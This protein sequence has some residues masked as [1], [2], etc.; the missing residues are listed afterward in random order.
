MY[1]GP[2]MRYLGGKSKVGKR[3]AEVILAHTTNR[4]DYYEPFFGGGGMFKHLGPRFK[5][6]FASD[7]HEDL[8]LM[9]QAAKDGWIPPEITEDEYAR[10]RDGEPSALRGFAG[11][12]CSFGG[13]W[14][15]G[16]ARGGGRRYSFESSRN[17]QSIAR[18][19]R[20]TSLAL[21]SYSDLNPTRGSV[22]YA[23][24]PYRGTTEYS[25][26]FNHD[27]FWLKAK[28][29]SELG[30]L[31]HVSEYSA[32]PEWTAI[33]SGS[34]T[35]FVAKGSRKETTEKLFVLGG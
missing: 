31:V 17:V 3:I 4:G 9:W 21:C 13:K 15:G 23:D 1:Y 11:F 10:L 6:T 5:T 27:A 16:Y 20:D 7:V 28:E 34:H 25:H 30:V 33:W 14:F 18:A 32:P 12:G 24:P 8:M 2:N 19:I 22:V 29:W 35:Q 26:E